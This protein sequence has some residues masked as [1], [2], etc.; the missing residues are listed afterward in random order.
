MPLVHLPGTGVDLYY[1]ERGDGPPLLLIFG[2]TG[3]ATGW[4]RQL[5]AFSPH[6]RTI[7]FDNRGAGRSTAPPGAYTIEEMA[8]DA[9]GLLDVLGVERAHVLGHSMGGQVAQEMAIR[10]PE[11]LD[12]L[13]LASTWAR[14]DTLFNTV[15]D[16]WGQLYRQGLDLQTCA[17]FAFTWLLTAGFLDAAG[18]LDQ[19]LG[20][21]ASDPFPPPAQGVWGQSRAIIAGDTRGRLASIRA[22]TLVIVGRQDILTPVRFSEDLAWGIPNATL[23]VLERGGHGLLF[24]RPADF[25]Q[26]IL[27]FLVPAPPHS[28]MTA[29]THQR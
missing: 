8:A 22:P 7:I 15:I 3:N 10:A 6:F 29:G 16:V 5:P 18:A 9:V 20:L 11:R 19:M 14:S 21:A 24:E 28:G 26:A 17:K 27:D 23:R 12:R 4:A 13:V 25:N 1:E 2:F